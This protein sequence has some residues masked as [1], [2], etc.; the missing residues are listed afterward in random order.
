MIA[1]P[2]WDCLIGTDGGWLPLPKGSFNMCPHPR[3]GDP[4]K[5]GAY[6]HAA[7]RITNTTPKLYAAFSRHG[8]LFLTIY[9]LMGSV[10]NVTG[11]F[12]HH[13][14]ALHQLCMH[15]AD[16]FVHWPERTHG[17]NLKRRRARLCISIQPRANVRMAFLITHETHS[18]AALRVLAT[19]VAGVDDWLC[20]GS[21]S[22]D[23][24]C[25]FDVSHDPEERTDLAKENPALVREL[26]EVLAKY[27][28]K[29]VPPYPAARDINGSTCRA[30]QN[31][32]GGYLGPWVGS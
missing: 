2:G 26:V 24:P 25:M 16:C 17:T 19:C 8:L 3:C 29:V 10:K 4:H 30:F 13:W 23:Q 14:L 1:S 11:G 6:M 9:E 15:L 20:S 31:R 32:W 28:R 22:L 21:C 27:E 18:P 5:A 7:L 12:T